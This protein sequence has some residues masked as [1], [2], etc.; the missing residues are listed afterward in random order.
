[1]FFS[2]FF[3]LLVVVV[4]VVGWRICWKSSQR[5]QNKKFIVIVNNP[6]KAPHFGYLSFPYT[7]I[8]N[9]FSLIILIWWR[10]SQSH[11]MQKKK[12]KKNITTTTWN[13]AFQ[14]FLLIQNKVM[15]A[16]S[17]VRSS[18]LH[19]EST[20]FFFCALPLWIIINKTYRG[21]AYIKKIN[22]SLWFQAKQMSWKEF[23][24]DHHQWSGIERVNCMVVTHHLEP[25]FQ[26]LPI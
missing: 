17:L 10:K 7:M 20:V 16:H 26:I 25:L 3:S 21:L 8:N 19:Y 23:S 12:T 11:K 13:E 9:A 2:S 15:C 22:T 18:L 24:I 14:H 5:R 6:I 4:V 1:M